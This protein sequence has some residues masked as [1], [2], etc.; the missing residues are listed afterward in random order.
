MLA[1]ED[2]RKLAELP[3]RRPLALVAR[4]GTLCILHQ[5]AAGGHVVSAAALAAG[6]PQRPLE[7]L[8]TVPAGI[9]PFDLEQDSHG[10]FYLSDP[11]ANKV[12]QVDH[13]GEILRTFGRLAVQKPGSYDPE[14]LMAPGKLAT[15][16]DP[17]GNDRLLVVDGAGPTMTSEWSADGKQLRQFV[18]LQTNSN[19]YG[20]A[21]DPRQPQDL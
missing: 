10:R 1:G 8:F 15:W 13:T 12:Y 11:G 19:N 16:R 3:V 5:N 6:I 17:D 9:K 21:V 14:T 7:P 2:G 4:Y 20:Y 18:G